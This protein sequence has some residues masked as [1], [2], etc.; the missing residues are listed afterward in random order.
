MLLQLLIRPNFLLSPYPELLKY[1]PE[2]YWYWTPKLEETI[3]KNASN[4]YPVRF[5]ESTIN[6]AKPKANVVKKTNTG[7]GFKF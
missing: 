5:L 2:K 4:Q 3:L 1:L 6:Q 7:L